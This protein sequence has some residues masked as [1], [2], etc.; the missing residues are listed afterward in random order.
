MFK[1]P[2]IFSPT[3]NS[4]GSE[5]IQVVN[6]LANILNDFTFYEENFQV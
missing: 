2:F 5:S 1:L 4:L 6:K 3:V